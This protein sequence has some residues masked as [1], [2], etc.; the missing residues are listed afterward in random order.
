MRISGVSYAQRKTHR[1][2]KIIM[3][4]IILVLLASIA[5][6]GVS[7]YTGWMLTHP[8]R[9]ALPVFSS[10]IVPEYRNISFKDIKDQI[11]L[12]GWFFEVKGSNKTVIIA[13]G[14]RQNR[15]PHGENSF[16]LIKYLLNQGY[17]VL[18]FDF[19]NSGESEGKVTTVGIYE[20][21][22]LLGA[23]KHAK[24]LGSKQI[25]LLGF[26]MG[27]STS[28]VAASES[29]DVDAVIADSPFSDLEEYLDANLSVWSNLPSFPF[30]Q[31]TYL[32]MKILEGINPKEFSPR[33]VIKDI[34][35]RPVFLI[36]SK[37]DTMIPVENSYELLNAGGNNVKL[38]ETK[39]V[40]HIESYPKLTDEYLKKLGEFLTSLSEDSDED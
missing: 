12:K 9:R 32:S 35:P 40:D 33:A 38:W 15:L 1:V 11:T 34:A 6:I 23:I 29:E 18:T 37:D 10:N 21:D 24:K 36:H 4:L 20:K 30:N 13:H 2:R 19:R 5:L 22:D 26:S 25:V 14:Y 7:T 17:N 31:T 3:A 39:D 28:I 16:P 8:K 27:A